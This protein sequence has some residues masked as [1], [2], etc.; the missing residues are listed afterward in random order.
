MQRAQR[1]GLRLVLAP[2]CILEPWRRLVRRGRVGAGAGGAV[3]ALGRIP[4]VHGHRRIQLRAHGLGS[5]SG[6][7]RV[8]APPA[9]VLSYN[10]TLPPE[11][12]RHPGTQAATW[13]HSAQPGDQL[14]PLSHSAASRQ[15]MR[16]AQ[17]LALQHAAHGPAGRPASAETAPSSW[18]RTLRN[19][20]TRTSALSAQKRTALR[21]GAPGGRGG[22][23]GGDGTRRAAAAA[24]AAASV[25][26]GGA[27]AAPRPPGPARGAR[28][29]SAAGPTQHSSGITACAGLRARAP[30]LRGSAALFLGSGRQAAAARARTQHAARVAC[31]NTLPR[32][33]RAA[34]GRVWL[35][36]VGS[37]E[38]C[39]HACHSQRAM[40]SATGA[41]PVRGC[42]RA[43]RR[44]AAHPRARRRPTRLRAARQ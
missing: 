32:R 23:G 15:S 2:R 20:R 5:G 31:M 33:A 25:A 42:G 39:V 4:Q 30:R 38:G 34:L 11:L 24:R 29:V 35:S 28:A 3:A 36:K 8:C 22:R 7:Q 10:P 41:R 9:G 16:A 43:C 37:T 14:R 1:G 27:S 17:D 44:R 18:G 19:R 26:G 21:G 12:P 6:Q 40:A 13:P